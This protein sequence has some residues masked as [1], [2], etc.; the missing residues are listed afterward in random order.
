MTSPVSPQSQH[1]LAAPLLGVP[2]R[3]SPCSPLSNPSSANASFGQPGNTNFASNVPPFAA[4]NARHECSHSHLGTTD[5]GAASPASSSRDEAATTATVVTAASSTTTLGALSPSTTSQQYSALASAAST[6][7]AGG[8]HLYGRPRS[9]TARSLASSPAMEG[10]IASRRGSK[11]SSDS[12]TGTFLDDLVNQLTTPDYDNPHDQI[13]RTNVFLM[14]YRKFLRPRDLLELFIDRFEDQGDFVDTDLDEHDL[15][16]LEARDTRLRICTCLHHWL[17][18][19][20]NDFVHP[21]TRQRLAAFLRERVALFPYLQNIY[22]SL[23]PLSSIHYFNTWRSLNESSSASETAPATTSHATGSAVHSSNSSVSGDGDQDRPMTPVPAVSYEEMDDDKEWGLFDTDEELPEVRLA[24]HQEHIHSV[25]PGTPTT[26]MSESESLDGT[27]PMDTLAPFPLI[28]N[29]GRRNSRTLAHLPRD[30]R[31]S[32]GSLTHGC[33]GPSIRESVLGA[34]RGSASSA[35]SHPGY[36]HPSHYQPLSGCFAEGDS[37]PM[38]LQPIAAIPII[39]KRSSSQAYRQRAT[40]NASNCAS[41]APAQAVNTNGSHGGG[42]GSTSSHS[43]LHKTP[44]LT[45]VGSCLLDGLLPHITHGHH[46]A[47]AQPPPQPSANVLSSPFME[48][49]DKAVADQLTCVEFGLFRKLKPRDML[50][51]VWKSGKGSVAFQACIAHFNFISSWV[52]TMILAPPKVKHR[53]KMMEKFISI[54]KI[55]R[56]N[57]NYNTTMAIVGAMNTSSIHR[58]VQTREMLQSKDIWNTFKEL[59]KLMSS[60]R[61]FAEYRAAL[62]ATEPPCIPYLGVHLAD[63][64]SISEGNKDF[65]QDGS[66]HWQKF[67]LMADV[68]STVTNFQTKPYDIE[69]D[70]FISRII[71]ETHVLDDEELYTKSVGTE[72]NKLNHSRSLSFK[73][74]L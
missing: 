48:I 20:P 34:R 68:I 57:G 37:T 67:V 59:E 24:Q 29:A 36:Y 63:L 26:I 70:P 39:T 54:A 65:R 32:T 73:L 1:Q 7:G 10:F 23:L 50:R 40:S 21:Q 31:S 64:L 8:N 49:P 33:T 2:G 51:Q 46:H 11:D 25:V 60:E 61:S 28:P 55:L 45:S 58:L 3:D 16:S 41:H 38:Q 56:Q 22:S 4:Q 9:I 43:P 15:A 5:P 66:I 35:S 27:S 18:H 72:P 52:G 53:A 30:R 13:A 17:K 74:F 69:P 44:S 71:T 19:F 42:G 6:S 62:K 12:A 14:I 47:H